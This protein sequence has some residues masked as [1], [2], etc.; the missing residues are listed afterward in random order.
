MWRAE[1]TEKCLELKRNERRIG[2]RTTRRIALKTLIVYDSVHGNT[3]SI[4]K[5]IG[6][7]IAGEVEVLR[8]G[9]VS[10]SELETLDLLIV[11][12]P[13]HG[14]KATEA[15]QD[16]LEG[17]PLSTLEGASV[18]AFDTRFDKDFPSYAAPRI[19]DT[20]KEKGGTLIG[21]PEGFIVEGMEGPLKE[22]EI[23]RAAGWAKEIVKGRK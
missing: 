9:Q 21:S 7:A 19:A 11:G 16:F 14:G 5:A 4:A 12:S 2:Q 13:T 20:L 17:A 6:D 22:G 18:A 1:E 3:E 15:I 8:V 10:A 23:E